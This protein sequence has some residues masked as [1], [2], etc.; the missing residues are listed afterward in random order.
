[1]V[2]W[3]LEAYHYPLTYSTGTALL[4]EACKNSSTSI[5]SFNRLLLYISYIVIY[6]Q[7]EAEMQAMVC[8]H[9]HW[10]IACSNNVRA[11]Q[12]YTVKA[13]F[14]TYITMVYQVVFMETKFT[15][16]DICRLEHHWQVHWWKQ[17]HEYHPESPPMVFPLR[18]P[19][20]FDSLN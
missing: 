10:L 19:G 3:L 12:Y 9:L 13:T 5:N 15:I 6:N 20:L 7:P 8:D 18:F 16:C 2:F 11:K 14:S 17:D 1:M 4:N